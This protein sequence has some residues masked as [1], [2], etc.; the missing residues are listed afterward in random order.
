M[1]LYEG[2]GQALRKYL[3]RKLSSPEDIEDIVQEAYTRVLHAS[4][5]NTVKNPPAFLYRT[6][7]NLVVDKYRNAH[8]EKRSTSIDD[9][10]DELASDRNSPEKDSYSKEW[11]QAL[12]GAIDQLPPKCRRVFIMHKIQNMT[13][14]EISN[15]LG[16]SRSMTEKHMSKA[17]SYC[18]NRLKDFSPGDSEGMI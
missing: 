16:I 13:Y 12:R 2:N 5:E 1:R 4:Q 8:H 11:L 7:H 10:M 9:C 3:R 15:E 14:T 18:R 17:L 6:A